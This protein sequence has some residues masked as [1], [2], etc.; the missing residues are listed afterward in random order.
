[1]KNALSF[2]TQ[3][4]KKRETK[5][6]I[7]GSTWDE[8]FSDKNGRCG[9]Y[10]DETS[11][12]DDFNWDIKINNTKDDEIYQAGQ[13]IEDEHKLYFKDENSYDTALKQYLIMLEDVDILKMFI[14]GYYE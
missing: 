1:M 5:I 12:E 3:K 8:T 14:T 7:D 6:E 9:N 4:S 2:Y 11:N 10:S 13:I